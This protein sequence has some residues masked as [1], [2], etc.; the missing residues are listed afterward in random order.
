MKK[1]GG[2]VVFFLLI[3]TSCKSKQTHLSDGIYAELATDKGEIIVKLYP[4]DTPLTVA[5][6]VSLAEGTSLRVADSL[7]GKKFYDGLPFH[8]VISDFM[9]QGGDI[10]RNGTGDPGYKFADEFPKNQEGELLHSHSKKGMLSMANSGPN[11]NGSQFFITHKSTPWLD[12]KHTVFG[13]V[14]NGLSVVD[15]IQQGDLI[16]SIRIK[17]RGKAFKSYDAAKVFTESLEALKK[18][19]VLK[20]QLYV[21]DSIVFSKKMKESEAVL[22]PSGLKILS[23]REG[24]GR[25]PT[26]GDKIKVH[27]VGYFS[28]GEVLDSSYERDQTLDFTVGVDRVIEGWTQGVQE[29]EEE[30]KA[31][32]F[33]PY[34]LAYGKRG[35]G[36]IP[37]KASLIFDV[38]IIKIE[39]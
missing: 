22:S 16:N 18:E 30:G 38:E 2:F 10:L 6:F 9:I 34:Q 7:K 37:A 11:T 24:N 5:N 25:K 3:L 17:R 19:A 27:Y 36:P 32:L 39:K 29:I 20:K 33:I 13:E 15:S 31:R 28:N 12:G 14:V 26:N 8:R 35:Y 23:L 4:E 1:I 21:K